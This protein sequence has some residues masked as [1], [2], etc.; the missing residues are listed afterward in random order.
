MKRK[1]LIG[2]AL[3]TALA[4]TPAALAAEQGQRIVT[5]QNGTGYTVSS[6][7]RHVVAADDSSRTFAFAPTN[8]YDLAQLVITDGAFTD[9][10]DVSTLDPDLTMHGVT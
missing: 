4:L 10:A 5:T 3:A 6:V 8:G 2:A 7:G 9:R 1:Q